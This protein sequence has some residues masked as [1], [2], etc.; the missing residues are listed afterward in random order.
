MA[1]MACEMSQPK[2][3][4]ADVVVRV[5]NRRLSTSFAFGVIHTAMWYDPLPPSMHHIATSP[6]TPHTPHARS[7]SSQKC[8]AAVASAMAAHSKNEIM[9]DMGRNTLRSIGSGNRPQPLLL[10]FGGVHS[11]RVEIDA[12]LLVHVGIGDMM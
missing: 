12:A 4:M 3:D 2:I 11:P 10:T 5:A 6:L 8:V 1:R 7:L 9:Q